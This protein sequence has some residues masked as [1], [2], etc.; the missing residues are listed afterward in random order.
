MTS[1]ASVT[2]RASGE[3]LSSK[4]K[5]INVQKKYPNLKQVLGMARGFLVLDANDA[6]GLADALSQM[7]FHTIT[8]QVPKG[9]HKKGL[10][11]DQIIKEKLGGRILITKNAKDFIA[12]A[13]IY[14]FGII[15]L[16]DLSFID[17][18]KSQKNKT[19]KMISKAITEFSLGS[20]K[21]FILTL[22][23][24]G[25]HQFTALD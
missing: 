8:I 25:K 11:D 10:S 17:K 1:V 14:D 6:L 20:Q 2:Y 7:N 4:K 13:P 12:A 9:Q 15:S 18:D 3:R 19:A 5:E 24:T 21:A 16:E 22:K 23:A